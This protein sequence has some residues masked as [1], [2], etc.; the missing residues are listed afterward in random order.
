MKCVD[1]QAM[2]HLGRAWKLQKLC[3]G[4]GAPPGVCLHA[5][6]GELGHQPRAGEGAAGRAGEPLEV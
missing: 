1:P 4:E 5:E 2:K 3:S 6:P